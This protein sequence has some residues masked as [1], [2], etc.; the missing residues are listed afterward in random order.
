MSGNR[1]E[2]VEWYVDG[3]AEGHGEPGIFHSYMASLATAVNHVGGSLDPV[4]LMGSSGF[5]FRIFVNEVFCPSAMSIFPWAEV[6]P[7]AVEQAG[8]NCVYVS[9]MW[10]DGE[11]EDQRREEAHAAILEGIDRG[12][13][14]VVWDIANTEWGLIVGYDEDREAYETLTTEGQPSS[15]SCE[16]L[17]KN[18]IDVLSVAIPGEAN[19]RSRDDVV[20]NSLRA[21]VAHADGEEWT[22]R[23]AYQNGLAAFD[24]WATLYDRWAMIVG[25]GKGDNLPLDLIDHAA[26]YAGHFYSARCY[27]RDYLQAIAGENELLRQAASSYAAVACHL[28]PVWEHGSEKRGP[29]RALLSS[30]AGHVR[31]AKCSEER[32]IA[33]IREHLERP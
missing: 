11:L 16:R 6:L 32:A 19:S 31:E 13:P 17:G 23:P 22:E 28:R 29:D 14:A 4:W 24:L 33:C 21:A 18:G 27:A 1:L 8:Y 30:L 2:G 10:D 15:L 9:R 5:A 12:A 7:E 25:A 26:Y 3:K 20:L